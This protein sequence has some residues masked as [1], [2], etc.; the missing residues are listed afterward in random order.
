[1]TPITT[2]PPM[3]CRELVALVTDYLDGALSVPEERSFEGHLDKCP[4]C[5]TYLEQMRQTIRM[6]GVLRE[7]DIPL[8]ARAELLVAF[9][10]WREG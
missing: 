4:P 10:Q 3:S 1:M 9:R 8:E 5:V 2:V 7:Q 6:A